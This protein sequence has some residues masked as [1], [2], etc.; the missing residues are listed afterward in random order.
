MAKF[1]AILAF[2]L[3]F[4]CVLMGCD[5]EL[6]T[7]ASSSGEIVA[8][9]KIICGMVE[10]T[11]DQICCIGASDPGNR[12]C[13]STSDCANINGI[14]AEC[15]GPEDCFV[16]QVC[17]GIH[18]DAGPPFDAV[19]CDDQCAEPNA[20]ICN[21]AGGCL[22]GSMCEMEPYLGSGFGVCHALPN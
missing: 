22:S 6:P 12:T 9:R 15:N 5:Y 3:A 10:C 7:A 14:P 1:R 8:T 20:R 2:I 21:K 17:C 18:N 16:T 11:G 13:R 4:V 19:R